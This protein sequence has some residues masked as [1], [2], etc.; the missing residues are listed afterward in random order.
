M[1]KVKK[2]SLIVSLAILAV[3]V[4]ALLAFLGLY[5]TRIQTIG[6]I[7]RL[8]DD[9]DGYNLYRMDVKYDYNLDNII[10]YGIQDD[11]TMIDAI[12]KEALPLLPVKIKAPNFGCTVFC[13]TDTDG[14]VHM[15]RNYDFSKDTSAM[16]VYC[17]PKD[18]Y[19]SIAFAALD[20]VSANVPDE[21]IKKEL[22]SLTAPFI[23][24]DGMNEKGVSIA[25]LTLD[26]EPVRQSTGKP[27]ISTTLAIRLVL[28]RAATTEEAVELLR[29]YDMFASSGRDYHFYITDAS[30][31]GRV[32][33]YDINGEPREL[34][35]TP[36][37]AVTNF[38]IRHKD[39]VLPNQKNGIYGHGR[40]RYDAVLEVLETEKGNYTDDTVWNAM[41]AAAQDP[42][43]D[44]I[45]SNTQW[46]ISYNNTDLS[47]DIAIRRH[48]SDVTHCELETKVTT[49]LK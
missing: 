1:N 16:L 20:N 25:V 18:R 46:S 26:S 13:L 35:D 6:S 2:R 9:A 44:N 48:W 41:K 40:E 30:G 43:P 3:V 8:T 29:S 12:L 5:F 38:F 47:A 39:E 49:P 7:E 33:E 10:D 4:F 32:I 45:T 36:S 23:C 24:L 42:N 14:D 19:K 22:A 34:I 31:D 37:E 17:A 28:D 15:G 21:N 11:Q 27:V